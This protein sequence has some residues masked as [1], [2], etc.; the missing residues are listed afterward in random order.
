MKSL[1]LLIADL[2]PVSD[3]ALVLHEPFDILLS[4]LGDFIDIKVIKCFSIPFSFT[5]YGDPAQA[6]LGTF[7][8]KELKEK[9]VVRN[10]P[11]PFFIVVFDIKAV[12]AAPTASSIEQVLHYVSLRLWGAEGALA[13][14]I[15]AIIRQTIYQSTPFISK[16]HQQSG[17]GCQIKP[18]P[19]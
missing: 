2:E 4:H 11:P 13:S 14:P 7:Q 5:Q 12:S 15:D 10:E 17:A 9:P 3:N 16:R 1:A 8:S 19:L 6:S 18:E